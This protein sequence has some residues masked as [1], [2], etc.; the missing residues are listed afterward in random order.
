MTVLVGDEA[1]L[2]CA[3][4]GDYVVWSVNGEIYQESGQTEFVVTRETIFGI[5]HCNL[6]VPAA[7][8][9]NNGTTARCIMTTFSPS[10]SASS[11]NAILIVLPG[12]L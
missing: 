5:Q 11:D 4:I 2:Q 1:T 9:E 6:T 12:E 8:D 7:S 3:G 10:S